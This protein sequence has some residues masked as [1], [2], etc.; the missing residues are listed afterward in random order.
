MPAGPMAE[1]AIYRARVAGLEQQ[2]RDALALADRRAREAWRQG[3]ERGRGA[4][5]IGL[6]LGA[7]SGSAVT[8][9]AF[10]I[11]G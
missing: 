7:M 1:A 8:G 5:L 6:L 10:V 11:F 2:L 9:L 4:V 3:L